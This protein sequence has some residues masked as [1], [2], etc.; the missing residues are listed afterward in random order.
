MFRYSLSCHSLAEAWKPTG[1]GISM[2]K[3]IKWICRPVLED[4]IHG[5]WEGTYSCLDEIVLKM[6]KDYGWY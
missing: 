4:L 6:R 5:C 1:K 3:L 2:A